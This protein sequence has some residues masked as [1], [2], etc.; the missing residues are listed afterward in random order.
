MDS[1]GKQQGPFTL[2]QLKGK[3]ISTN[4]MIWYDSLPQWVK[5]GA[6]DSL[7]N[8]IANGANVVDWSK[9]LFYY[10]DASGQQ[11]P[12]TLEQLKGKPIISSTPVWYDPLPQWTTAGQVEGLRNILV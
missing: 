1:A 12:F 3:P 2:E 11:G 6:D 7:R 4:T 10:T 5:A 9:K 8:V